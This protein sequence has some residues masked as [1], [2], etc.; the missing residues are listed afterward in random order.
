L[1][2]TGDG[3]E[4]G[5]GAQKGME[6]AVSEIN[7]EG[8]ING[9]K[10]KILYED[11]ASQPGQAVSALQKLIDA[12]KP[13]IV[14]G[15]IFSTL[16]LAMAPVAERNHV[17][18][19]SPGSSNP[20]ITNAGDYIFR[21]YPSDNYEGKISAEYIFGQLGIKSVTILYVN[22]DYGVGLRDV[23]SKRYRELGGSVALEEAY[24]QGSSDFRTQLVKAQKL[25]P[26][27]VYVPGYY[28]D[29][30]RLL[31]QAHELGIKSRF[32]G[33]VGVADPKIFDIAGQAAE[34]LLFTAPVVDLEADVR[35]GKSFAERF[36][37]K[38]G[39]KPGFPEA[40]SYDAVRIAAIAMEKGG[41]TAD[42]I[43][44]ALYKVHDY[45]GVTGKTS[46]DKNGDVIKP[47]E[48]KEM[49]QGKFVTAEKQ[50]GNQP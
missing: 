3:A 28:A 17:V 21:N 43:K 31:K 7:E 46:F 2:L 35:K 10:L 12:N 23:F 1:E 41:T 34:G 26:L 18:L 5:K 6:L 37:A 19:L 29:V 36:Q 45:S 25:K 14:L 13:P 8:G 15:A 9:R 50:L 4:I 49:R 16:T 27:L 48:I 47:F 44:E 39:Q 42:G 20:N 22:N 38:W 24:K 32:F 30:G 40:Y 33:N 11:S